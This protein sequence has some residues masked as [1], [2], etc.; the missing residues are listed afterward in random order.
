MWI[1]W[2]NLAGRSR[3]GIELRSTISIG[4]RPGGGL[5]APVENAVNLEA[6]ECVQRIL[7]TEWPNSLTFISNPAGYVVQYA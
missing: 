7:I 2:S 3:S 4:N 1:V 6:A 5:V